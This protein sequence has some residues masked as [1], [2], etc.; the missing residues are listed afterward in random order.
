MPC[1]L[2]ELSS[3]KERTVFEWRV[4]RDQ[5]VTLLHLLSCAWGPLKEKSKWSN[6]SNTFAFQALQ[7]NYVLY[8]AH[9]HF[10]LCST[11]VAIMIIHSENVS[12]HDKYPR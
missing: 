10:M 4:P 1:L 2:Y 7:N 8:I 11:I 5:L 3:P 12:I 9:M 6:Y